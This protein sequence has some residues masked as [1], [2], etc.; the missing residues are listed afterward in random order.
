MDSQKTVISKRPPASA[1]AFVRAANPYEMGTALTGEMLGHF[2][3]EEFV[4]GGGMGAVFRATDTMLGRTVAVKVVSRDETNEDSLRRFRNEAQSAARLDHPNIAR[5]YYVGEDKGW[6]YIVFEY[7]EGINVRDLV[8]HNGPLTLEEAVTCTL[9]IAEAL[10]HASQR[11]V[12]HRDIKPSNILIMI[13]GRAKLVDMGLARLRQVE[14]PTEDLTASGVTLGTFDYISPEQARDPRNTDVRSDLYSLGC[15]LFFMLTGQPPFPDGTVLQ[16]LLSHSSEEPPDLLTYR[17]DLPGDIVAVVKKM[18]AKLPEQR[19]QSPRELIGELLLLA[20]RLNLTAITANSTVWLAPTQPQV[21]WWGRHMPWM[22]PAA[23]LAL[24][25]LVQ[26][27]FDQA[28]NVPLPPPPHLAARPETHKTQTPDLDSAKPPAG[29]DVPDAASAATDP[30]PPAALPQKPAADPVP[31]GG[32]PA[33]DDEV[34]APASADAN[35][36]ATAAPKPTPPASETTSASEPAPPATPALPTTPPTDGQEP[37]AADQPT[38]NADGTQDADRRKPAAAATDPHVLVV[39]DEDVRLE[40]NMLGVRSLEE[41]ID[42]AAVLSGVDEIQLRFNG[43]RAVGPLDLDLSRFARGRLTIRPTEGYTPILACEAGSAPRSDAERPALISAHSGQITW[44]DTHFYLQFPPTAEDR[45]PRALFQLD[46]V[47][48]AEFSR[49]SFTIRNVGADGL[50]AARNVALFDL[51]P[52]DQL[53]G[54]LYDLAELDDPPAIRLTDCIARGQISLVRSEQATPFWLTWEH[55]LLISSEQ[56]VDLGGAIVDPPWS[57]GHVSL[58]LKRLLVFADRGICRVR[59]DTNAPYPARVTVKSQACLFATQLTKPATPLYLLRGSAPLA[60][61][62]SQLAISGSNN[63]YKNTRVVL[64]VESNTDGSVFKEYTFDEL[65][66]R[67][68]EPSWYGERNPLPATGFSWLPPASSVD[69]QKLGDFMEPSGGGSWFMGDLE[70]A[71]A[72]LPQ[73]PDYSSLLPRVELRLP[74]PGNTP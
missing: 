57:L 73:F 29:T 69:R 48:V 15:T 55:G 58:S 18:L 56:L 23:V 66:E 54:L 46:G 61:D 19:F 30:A 6:N 1:P 4:G 41:A 32:T 13:D 47:P 10:D 37:R 44:R 62:G 33:A 39:S 22:A 8:E 11:D 31:P 43:I 24:I 26:T 20:D 28:S 60:E 50:P 59:T 17:P 40:R 68:S 27:W 65:Q 3:L 2:Q 7:I 49:C 36:S 63:F 70:I 74:R 64:R 42:R 5:V 14:S 35:D 53:A 34:Q 16:K 52:M 72:E 38:P 21:T 9:Q 12:T 71:P 51:M 67:R 45:A 25:V